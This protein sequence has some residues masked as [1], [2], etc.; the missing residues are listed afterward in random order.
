LGSY[1][2]KYNFHKAAQEFN[3]LGKEN[4]MEELARKWLL[5]LGLN[6]TRPTNTADVLGLIRKLRPQDCGKELIRIGA[7]GDGGYLVPDD[8]EGIEYCFSPGVNTSSHFEDHLANLKIRSFLAD[9]S[10]DSPPVSRPEF[11]FDKKFLG[12][13]DRAMFF[14]LATW[15]DKYLKNY[16]GDLILQ[17]D[18]EG[19]EYEVILSTPEDLLK[20]FRIIV[21]EF[22]FLD[23]VF[24]RFTFGII[25][26]CFDKLLQYFHVA[27]IH[28]N[29]RSGSVRR[30]NVEVPRMIEFTFLNKNRISSTHPQCVFP[31]KLDIDNV[32]EM[33]PL[34]LPKCWYSEG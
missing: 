6:V 23:R 2:R 9:Y 1:A 33:P 5:A 11:T 10:V 27:H 28:P 7:D 14:T 22:H 19:Y 32:T 31:H 26:S 3:L 30:G 13:T 24:D 4:K 8:L 17:M 12:A 20:Q 25:L 29:N 15:K 21:I 18:I 16:T 34:R